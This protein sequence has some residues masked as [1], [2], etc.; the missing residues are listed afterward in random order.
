MKRLHLRFLCCIAVTLFCFSIC[1]VSAQAPTHP[2]IVFASTRNGN[3]GNAEIYV[4]NADGSQ[5]IRLTHYPRDDTDPTWSPNGE[6]IAFVSDRDHKGLPDIYLMDADGKNIRRAFDDLEF[7]TAPAWSP[8]GTQIAYLTY[9]PVPDWAVYTKP[10]GGGE[11]ERIAESGRGFSGFPA[12]SPDGTEIAFVSGKSPEWRIRII[13]IE[14]REED[15]LQPKIQGDNMLYPAWSPDGK[16]L[17]FSVWRWEGA[18]S[19]Y[20]AGRDGKEREE[21]VKNAFGT[22]AWSPDGKKLLYPKTVDGSDMLF[23]I[24]LDT[25][26][27]TLLA[28]V[29]P[30]KHRNGNIG[31][32]WFDP[33][34][35]PVSPE[36]QLLTTVW[37]KVKTTH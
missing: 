8:D 4:M 34:V 19:I 6:L 28:R 15:I 3:H 11:A 33:K 25:R 30:R 10:L 20:I 27:E 23:K 9:S 17:A 35:L 26:T 12:W 18:P 32:D 14:T 37:S 1:P 24:D 31:W 29:G 16:K 7:R 2:K 22:L 36:P 5:Q 13:N 21:I